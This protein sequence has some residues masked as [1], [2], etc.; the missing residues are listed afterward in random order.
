MDSHSIS[1]ALLGTE[2]EK[3]KYTWQ[4]MQNS[5]QK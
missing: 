1:N 4:E 5:L 2:K 3:I